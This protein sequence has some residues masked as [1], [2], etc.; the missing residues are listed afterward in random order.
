MMHEVIALNNMGVNLYQDSNSKAA[1]PVFQRAIEILRAASAELD[2]QESGRER[3]PSQEISLRQPIGGVINVQSGHF[4]VYDCALRLPPTCDTID[5]ANPEA[6]IRSMS[7]VI[8]LN[9]A[10]SFH[11]QAMSAGPQEPWIKASQVYGLVLQVLE[12]EEDEFGFMNLSLWAIKCLVLNNRAHL[13]YEEGEYQQCTSCLDDI[14]D[15]FRH[16]N[17]LDICIDL[18]SAG[19]IMANLAHVKPPTT[20]SAA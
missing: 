7:I 14:C 11:H 1:L 19:E 12:D 15:L 9:M 13:L 3:L 20:S 2:P 18:A 16:H 5:Q 4:Y 6:R 10:L 8:L 17:C